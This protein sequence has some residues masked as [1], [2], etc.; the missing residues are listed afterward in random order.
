MRIEEFPTAGL[1]IASGLCQELSEQFGVP[2]EVPSLA[3]LTTIGACFGAAAHGQ[4]RSVAGNLFS[5]F[6]AAP[7]SAVP[8]VLDIVFD[9]VWSSYLDS[10][11]TARPAMIASGGV[12]GDEHLVLPHPRLND[13]RAGCWKAKPCHQLILVG[14]G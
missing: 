7:G 6:G 9:P 14:L 3:A 1:G 8:M 5:I 10:L 12:V 13:E 11:L 4:G 2:I